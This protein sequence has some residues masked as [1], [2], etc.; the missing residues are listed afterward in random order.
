MQN[1]M[2]C[3]PQRLHLHAFVAG[4]VVMAAN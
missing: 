4:R 1:R 3:T 2:S